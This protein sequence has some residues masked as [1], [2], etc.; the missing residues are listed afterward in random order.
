VDLP[1]FRAINAITLAT[2]DMARAVRFYRALG[3]PLVSG[4][5]AAAFTSFAVGDGRLNLIA[6]PRGIRWGWW[7]RVIVYVDDVDRLHDRACAA[8]L[9]PEAPPRDA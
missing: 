9:S 6:A 5:E 8:G 7:G 4:G 1:Q 3:L 2:H